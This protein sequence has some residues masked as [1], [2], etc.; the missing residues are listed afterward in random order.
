MGE[1][2]QRTPARKKRR[3]RI[4]LAAAA[5]ALPAALAGGY[6][7]YVHAI[8][9][10]FNVVVPGRVYRSAWPTAAKLRQWSGRF[11]IRS[12]INL[13]A[14]PGD[15]RYAAVEAAAAELGL[16]VHYVRFR[17]TKRPL[18]Q[19]LLR[20]IDVLAT[21]ERPVLLHCRRGADRAGLAGVIAAMAVG[22]QSFAEA[23]K[24]LSPRYLHFDYRSGSLHGI[25]YDYEAHCRE[26][27][28]PTGGWKEFRIWIEQHYRPAN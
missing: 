19:T 3:R 27:G 24:Q 7:T 21:A 22:G 14:G 10:N 6:V 23:S 26:T 9:R 13:A 16:T 20:F 12:V 15:G 17:P 11:G 1:Q 25:L 18:R 8:E 5:V 4:L 28:L 2:A